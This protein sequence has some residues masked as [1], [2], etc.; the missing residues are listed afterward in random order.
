[1]ITRHMALSFSLQLFAQESE[2]LYYLSG[3]GFSMN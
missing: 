2:G 1:M 3:G